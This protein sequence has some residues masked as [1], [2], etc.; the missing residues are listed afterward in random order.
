M[1][2]IN[3]ELLPPSFLH[4][5]GHGLNQGNRQRVRG[6]EQKQE[7]PVWLPGRSTEGRRARLKAS[8]SPGEET[9][10]FKGYGR[11]SEVR[12]GVGYAMLAVGLLP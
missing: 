3:R 9:E 4:L 7:P 10:H 11:E 2:N 1:S 8:R 12:H 6:A 5:E